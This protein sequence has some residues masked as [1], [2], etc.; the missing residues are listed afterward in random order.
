MA[1]GT[2]QK[3]ADTSDET[4]NTRIHLLCKEWD[5]GLEPKTDWSPKK[6]KD[7]VQDECLF[8]IR[9]L[10]HKGR[11]NPALERFRHKAMILYKGWIHKPRAE[12]GVVPESTRDKPKP[13][14]SDE[15]IQLLRCLAGVLKEYREEWMKEN[16]IS[17]S[18]DPARASRFNDSPVPFPLI[19]ADSDSKRPREEASS[20]PP[21]NFKKP[22]S[23]DSMPPPDRGRSMKPTQASRSA[24]TS[25]TSDASSIFS[26]PPMFSNTQE[27]APDDDGRPSFYTQAFTTLQADR[28]SSDY[29]SSSF[30]AR[31]ADVPESEV[32]LADDEGPFNQSD[33]DVHVSEELS[34]DLL[35]F[36]GIYDPDEQELMN[37]LESVFPRQPSCLDSLPFP[38][39]YEITR[40]FLH[41]GVPLSELEGLIPLPSNLEDQDTLHAFFKDFPPLKGLPLPERCPSEVWAAA[42][43]GYRRGSHAVVFAGSLQVT[44]GGSPLQLQ[45]A[46]L[47]LDR[48]H[49]LG[50]RWGHDRFLEIIVPQFA[51]CHQKVIYDWLVDSAH[52]LLGRNWMPFH[53]KPKDRVRKQGGSRENSKEAA[54]RMFF[55]A[56]SGIGFCNNTEAIHD[57]DYS[58]NPPIMSIPVLLNRIRPTR[59]NGSKPALKLY[60]RTDLV[61]S[62]NS[63]TAVLENSQIRFQQRDILSGSE[64]MNDGAGRISP[65]LATEV[66]RTL[67]LSYLPSAFQGR[68]GEAKG[69]WVI[70]HSCKT[71]DLWI[72]I[73]PSQQ[74]WERSTKRNGESDDI[75]Q[76][77]FEV[78]KC[79]SQ[80]RSADLNTQFLDILMARARDQ[81]VMKQAI[82]KLF[83][84][85]LSQKLAD[86]QVAVEDPPS[87]R[88]WVRSS[89]PNISERLKTGAVPWRAGL[90]I[91]KE[92][93]LNVL[94][95]AGFDP[96]SSTFVKGLAKQV[97]KAKCEEMKDRLNI[98]VGQSTYAYMVPDFWGVLEADEVYID[99]SSFVDEISG[100]SGEVL[101]GKDVLVARSPAHF[102][103]DIQ[104]VRAVA[105]A[106]LMG[107][108]DVI[109]FPTKGNPSLAAKLSGGD[110]DG[111]MAWIC[112]DSSIVSNFVN[113]DVP[114]LP[115]LVQEGFIRQDVTTYSE[116]VQ[117]H[118]DPTSV[119]LKHAFAFN[120]R[121]SLLGSCTSYKE[122]V[123]YSTN[124]WDSDE[125]VYLSKLLSDLVDQPKQGFI[126]G[127]E[128]WSHFKQK[129]V[130]T[131][132]RQPLYKT[133][134]VRP[135]MPN[136]RD[137]LKYIAYKTINIALTGFHESLPYDQWW[138]EDLAAPYKRYRDEA[139][140]YPEWQ[141]VLDDLDKDLQTLKDA[142]IKKFAKKPS[143]SFNEESGPDFI[144]LLLSFFE[145]FHDIQPHVDAPH[146][147]ALLINFGNAELSQWALL[148]ASA[149]FSSYSR[150][151]VSNMVWWLAGKQYM[152][153]KADS[154]PGGASHSVTPGMY[155]IQK[156]DA[157]LIRRMRVEGREVLSEECASVTNVDDLDDLEDD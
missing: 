88:Q 119:F 75:S 107:L 86:L 48:S 99:F 61:V 151:Y 131:K 90:P 59:K 8:G 152:R 51:S 155:I 12:R 83:E 81:E 106:E 11:L 146:T 50:R 91:T 14:T 113:A 118:P 9:F 60:A 7:T 3:R 122:N 54:V 80:L 31:L 42:L 149:L 141:E 2:P 21:P 147:R 43:N 47:K 6:S 65:A 153:I 66:K 20:G 5:L 27:T 67:G 93:R 15:R 26:H 120:M 37:Q 1:P 32:I 111:D 125:A 137:H 70:D 132:P 128:E 72:E 19:K 116:L 79:S 142:W 114:K 39:V 63:A 36:G 115:D 133:D 130:P 121:Q 156:P 38:V 56:T 33:V 29:A 23:F 40:V 18:K 35:T 110:Y 105:K 82:Q 89:N 41:A 68:I 53:T 74:K 97:F 25:F 100:F 135:N 134:E 129:K 109:I 85:G 140:R 71:Q 145:Q 87:F 148:K 112:W 62:R 154:G 157:T 77:T 76:R 123:C 34:Q 144:P 138:D 96:R 104:K 10:H 55:F 136:I 57:P 101:N 17:P 64:V 150:K 52:P 30:E 45:L 22:R 73:Y 126:F 44:S 13:V 49:R 143:Q 139:K 102:I 46:P 92:E 69:L 58:G 28:K 108:K 98:T 103:S 95:D 4:L 117:G 127:E 124:S 24:N 94:L 16:G 84:D 78:L